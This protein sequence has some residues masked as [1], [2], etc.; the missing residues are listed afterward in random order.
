[1]QHAVHASGD[2]KKTTHT[3]GAKKRLEEK[4][5]SVM[6]Q[7]PMARKP[8]F[9][10]SKDVEVKKQQTGGLP[11]YRTWSALAAHHT[12]EHST[13]FAEAAHTSPSPGNN[14]ES[15][16]E[17]IPQSYARMGL[18]E[19]IRAET[20]RRA[21]M[22]IEQQLRLRRAEADFM[23]WAS[24]TK[25]DQ[26]KEK[27][28]KQDMNKMSDEQT[29]NVTVVN[30]SSLIDPSVTKS[31]HNEEEGK[32]RPLVDIRSIK[33]IQSRTRFPLLSTDEDSDQRR[34]YF[35]G[36]PLRGLLERPYGTLGT[37]D[38]KNT[39]Y[40]NSSKGV[41]GV[42]PLND[43]SMLPTFQVGL[44]HSR[45][46]LSLPPATS[47]EGVTDKTA[48]MSVRRLV[49]VPN[50]N[51]G[52]YA[53]L[54]TEW[55]KASRAKALT[56]MLLRS[57]ARPSTWWRL[58]GS[59]EGMLTAAR[60]LGLDSATYQALVT[61]FMRTKKGDKW[62]AAVAEAMAAATGGEAA[63]TAAGIDST[64][65]TTGGVGSGIH[66][67]LEGDE[68]LMGMLQLA[69]QIGRLEMTGAVSS[70][71]IARLLE[72]DED[73]MRQ[74][75]EQLSKSEE[76]QK[77]AGLLFSASEQMMAG[78]DDASFHE[79]AKSL[80]QEKR[81]AALSAR[82][83]RK[84]EKGTLQD[85]TTSPW[86]KRPDSHG[87]TDS[88]TGLKE[89]LPLLIRPGA[90]GGEQMTE[91]EAAIY[92]GTMSKSE[93]QAIIAAA[94][95]KAACSSTILGSD[96]NSDDIT[97]EDNVGGTRI[98][99][100][101]IY[102]RLP[103]LRG[104]DEGKAY[105]L[106]TPGIRKGRKV[107][108]AYPNAYYTGDSRHGAA[109]I[110]EDAFGK[111]KKPSEMKELLPSSAGEKDG[112]GKKEDGTLSPDD[113]EK[114]NTYRGP[115]WWKK[116]TPPSRGKADRHSAGVRDNATTDDR[117]GTSGS[118]VFDA[119][120]P[121]ADLV[122]VFT[123]P[124]QRRRPKRLQEDEEERLGDD[125]RSTR[126]GTRG[127]GDALPP[128]WTVEKIRTGS[129]REMS[130]KFVRYAYDG[131]PRKKSKDT[132]K[133]GISRGKSRWKVPDFAHIPKSAKRVVRQLD[134]VSCSDDDDNELSS[135]FDNDDEDLM[136][137]LA[138]FPE[139]EHHV[140]LRN[141]AK[142]VL[143]EL[144]DASSLLLNYA[145]KVR[146][147][148][149]QQQ[150]EG[151]FVP[152]NHRSSHP[153]LSA[154]AEEEQM[155]QMK[156]NAEEL[157]RR[158]EQE[159]REE[160]SDIWQ[161]L[162]QL[163]K[164]VEEQDTFLDD[165][166]LDVQR[167]SRAAV[168]EERDAF[169]LRLTRDVNEYAKTHRLDIRQL[170]VGTD[171]KRDYDVAVRSFLQSFALTRGRRVG[172]DVGCQCTPEDLGYVDPQI[173]RTEEDLEDLYFHARGLFDAIKLAIIAV[174]NVMSFHSSLELESTC[175]RCFYI[176][177]SPRTLWPCGHTFCQQCLSDLCTPQG[178]IICDECCSLCEV[179]YT[180]NLSLELLASY[181]I[182]QHHPYDDDDDDYEEEEVSSGLQRR[183]IEGVLAALLKD[184]MSTQ[185]SFGNTKRSGGIGG[186]STTTGKFRSTL[187]P[188]SSPSE[189][190]K[191]A[192][193]LPPV[194]V[195]AEEA[196][197]EKEAAKTEVV[198]EVAPT[199]S[200]TQPMI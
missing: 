173:R 92:W 197:K 110:D 20:L 177:E 79:L 74:Q 141:E 52:L 126:P 95:A 199:S 168:G 93:Q 140:R 71:E 193:S 129:A 114:D 127:K 128:S 12:G 104:L 38:E 44:S 5:L 145:A 72:Q 157:R 154:N 179:G 112:R 58:A 192:P 11:R 68:E 185:S 76:V 22:L 162:L 113:D 45:E 159:A 130:R 86:E 4:V 17:H 90:E 28:A 137:F 164:Q 25:D 29:T 101:D 65:G 149:Q 191:I 49:G 1:M 99:S 116:K 15:R 174:G 188:M 57:R 46:P 124:R 63:M 31:N 163:R 50:H 59:R 35:I 160:Y 67:L 186:M 98:S 195:A 70:E 152:Q 94:K 82:E 158:F 138:T 47:P 85:G 55:R 156:I 198:T 108:S 139:E 24:S 33:G 42:A 91:E 136:L 125:S 37:D 167:L 10:Q 80:L 3:N 133:E 87:S 34:Q 176:F 23:R 132:G 131:L 190:V 135:F 19:R 107:H 165:C 150:Q 26:E 14:N 69:R 40:V 170:Q 180:P 62:T 73:T 41:G 134:D 194:V 16:E 61:R 106:G 171:V 100:A 183:T 89:C 102:A 56:R 148:E 187:Q 64:P 78:M 121:G 178:E 111:T 83:H 146:A 2:K 84:G 60:A 75:L 8:V 13:P 166:E 77:Q 115:E 39:L 21:H 43:R 9:S 161:T 30:T 32:I 169:A 81:R 54:I 144:A 123:P 118:N 48:D 153:S 200:A 181:Q 142:G 96:E 182:V 122:E 105:E 66:S 189:P 51:R 97:V 143:G 196:K 151:L 117:S 88:F 53:A 7:Y 103:P 27:M 184:L 36:G 155:M 175:K 18:V 120:V 6:E 172:R 109:S 119:V 147:R